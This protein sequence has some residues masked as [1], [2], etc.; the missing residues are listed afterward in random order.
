MVVRDNRN[1]RNIISKFPTDQS[2]ILYS[3]WDGYLTKPDSTIPAFLNLAGKWEK[4]HTGGHASIQDIQTVIKISKPDKI[5]PI[6]TDSPTTL[7]D[8]C[9]TEKIIIAEDGKEISIE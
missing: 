6:H 1:F 5:I 3:M 7:Q 4:L 2:I 8:F 9:P